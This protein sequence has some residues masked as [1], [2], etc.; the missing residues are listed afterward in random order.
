MPTIVKMVGMSVP[1]KVGV[2]PKVLLLDRYL[3]ARPEKGSTSFDT[4]S[5]LG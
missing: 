2:F 3:T 1:R 4:A 5:N